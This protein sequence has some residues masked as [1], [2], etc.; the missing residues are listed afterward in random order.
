M[1]MS[2]AKL[3]SLS[4]EDWLRARFLTHR[5]GPGYL[6][7][8]S[9]A[10]ECGVCEGLSGSLWN[11]GFSGGTLD[12]RG[13]MWWETEQVLTWIWGRWIFLK[14]SCLPCFSYLTLL[15]WLS[16][17]VNL[18]S[19]RINW[20]LKIKGIPVRGFCLIWSRKTLAFNLDLETGRH[21]FHLGHTSFWKP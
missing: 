1:W 4:S 13:W 11:H 5:H 8:T 21:T 16:L 3:L 17:V 15:G 18:T 20:N 12:S 7:S 14:G 6:L 2:E 10:A 9:S 19:S